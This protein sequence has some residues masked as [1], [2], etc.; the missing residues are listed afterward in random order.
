M[1]YNEDIFEKIEQFPAPSYL[2]TVFILVAALVLGN[3]VYKDYLT[4]L[5][6]G[7]GGVPYNFFGYLFITLHRPFALSDFLEPPPVPDHLKETGHL[8]PSTL[9]T[10]K[11]TR[12][13]VKGIIPQRLVTDQGV[14]TTFAQVHSVFAALIAAYPAKCIIAQSCAESHST[15]LFSLNNVSFGRNTQPAPPE[16]CGG[17][18]THVHPFDGSL[19]VTLHPEDARTVIEAGWGER[20]PLANGWRFSKFLPTGFVILYA[21][22][23]NVEVETVMRIVGAAMGWVSGERGWPER[24]AE[25]AREVLERG[26]A[27]GHEMELWVK[28]KRKI[29]P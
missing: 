23:N 20:H 18:V 25:M 24:A 19:H 12:P 17:E 9:P 15:G 22:R 7:R 8:D 6:L 10:R 21:P 4:F 3:I 27:E 11:G 2:L 5:S 1:E 13:I 28:E 29:L 16:V 26:D 14:P